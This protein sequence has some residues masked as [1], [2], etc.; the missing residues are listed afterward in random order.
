MEATERWGQKGGG[1]NRV[2]VSQQGGGVSR[3]EGAVKRWG[4]QGGGGT[5]ETEAV[6]KWRQQGGKLAGSYII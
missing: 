6:G 5:R 1:C 4:Q 2:Q 3:E